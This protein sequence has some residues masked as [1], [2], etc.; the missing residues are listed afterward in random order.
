MT[1]PITAEKH[2]ELILIKLKWPFLI[3]KWATH[4]SDNVLAKLIE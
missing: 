4:V 1:R 2:S 3:Y